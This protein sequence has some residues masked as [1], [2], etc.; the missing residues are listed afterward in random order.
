MAARLLPLPLTEFRSH[1]TRWTLAGHRPTHGHAVCTRSCPPFLA[2]IWPRSLL[3][4]TPTSVGLK[5]PPPR[6]RRPGSSQRWKTLSASSQDGAARKGWW[7][8]GWGPLGVPVQGSIC[9]LTCWSPSASLFGQRGVCDRHPRPR[10]RR[11]LTSSRE[12]K[13]LPG[14]DRRCPRSCAGSRGATAG[15]LGPGSC[16]LLLPATKPGRASWPAAPFSWRRFL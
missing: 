2:Q 16:Q 12:T 5:S 11:C 10:E 4:L 13:G 3:S 14:L 8:G 7:E 6:P 9:S 1:R 15:G